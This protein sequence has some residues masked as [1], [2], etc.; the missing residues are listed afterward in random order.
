MGGNTALLKVKTGHADA[1][2]LLI[3]RDSYMDSLIPFL[4]SDFSEIDVMDLR[5]YKTQLMQSS[6]NDYV[7]E[8][9]IDEVLICYSVYNFGT[10]TNVF[11]LN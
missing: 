4:Q 3:I 5:Y 10:D 11:L 8:N 9:G 7:R 2:K 1:P 6:V